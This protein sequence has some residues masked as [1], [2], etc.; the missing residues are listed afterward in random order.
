MRD[1]TLGRE[2]EKKKKREE[3]RKRTASKGEGI[4]LKRRNP[5]K[6]TV[7]EKEKERGS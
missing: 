1:G 7:E 3:G 4:C 6:W 2:L 5:W